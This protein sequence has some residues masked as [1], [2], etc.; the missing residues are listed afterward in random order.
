MQQES[1][2]CFTPKQGYTTSAEQEHLAP[3]FISFH[4]QDFYESVRR[5]HKEATTNLS[6]SEIQRLHFMFYFCDQANFFSLEQ[7]NCCSIHMPYSL[8]CNIYLATAAAVIHVAFQESHLHLSALNLCQT[9]EGGKYWRY[10]ILCSV[11]SMF[12]CGS[13][14][15]RIQMPIYDH[16]TTVLII[17]NE[18]C[19]MSYTSLCSSQLPCYHTLK[20][21]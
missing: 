10:S 12:P 7:A 17:E 2:K 16:Q 11:R 6:P 14:K 8:H 5:D 18:I 4:F 19:Y 1:R 15:V 13:D 21:I 9:I 3:C 20:K